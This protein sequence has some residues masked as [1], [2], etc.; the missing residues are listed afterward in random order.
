MKPKGRH[1]HHALSAVKVN[2]ITAPGR[3]ADGNGL[4]LVVEETGAKRWVLR[5]V[6]QGTRTD[7]GL[8]GLTLVSLK[9]AREKAVAQRT[10]ARDGG[11]PRQERRDRDAIPTF[12][13]A[14]RTVHE[15]YSPT[16][17]NP[18]HAA[19]W[20]NTLTEYVF[21]IFGKKRV[22]EVDTPDVKRALSPIWLKKPETARRVKQRIG[23]VLDWAK[24]SGYRTG[25]NPVE[26]VTDGLP[27]QPKNGGHHAAMKYADVGAFIEKLRAHDCAESIRLAFEFM[28]L[29]AART[30]GVIG[31]QWGEIE[32]DT[33]TIAAA[34]M[35]AER[36]HRVPLPA[37][38]SQILERA[39]E[40]GGAYV[41]PGRTKDK[42]LSNMVFL[43]TLRRMDVDTTAHGFR[44]SFRDWS[45][46]QTNYPRD[47]AE[48][49]L[50]HTIK[51]KTEAAYR[52][53]DLF[54]K[55]A[56]LMAEWERHC[57][58][59]RKGGDVVPMRAKGRA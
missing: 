48:M 7:L 21:P 38:C 8:G 47:V 40:L 55:R 31:A 45:A 46:E 5:T 14:A 42:P 58:T 51:D 13:K 4:Y 20:I 28:I 24:T 9:T 22:S 56:M 15:E 49:A 57:A 12:E 16:W 41:F 43:M 18:K 39:R 50:A 6:V 52:R 3:Y 26:A 29:T 32:G 36:E 1:P 25:D 11:D 23:T 34:R 37:R 35:K 19:Q 54:E 59:V 53:G 33:W 27:D 10:I 2:S 30:G 17:R 44:S